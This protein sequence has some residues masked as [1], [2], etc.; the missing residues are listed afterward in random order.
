[1][2]C[3]PSSLQLPLRPPLSRDCRDLLQRLLERDPNRRISFQDFFAHPW[4]DLEHVPSGESLARAVS[5][6]VGWGGVRAG[7]GASS[8]TPFSGERGTCPSLFMVS[9]GSGH[10]SRSVPQTALVVQAV[11]KDQDGDAAAALSLYCKAL[12]FFVPALHC[13]CL[14]PLGAAGVGQPQLRWMDSRSSSPPRILWETK[15][16]VNLELGPFEDS[17]EFGV[18]QGRLL[19]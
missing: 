16:R 9:M 10:D 12:D 14:E 6:L 7:W 15:Q 5:R 4:V 11:K 2:I 8:S 18:G 13:E 17:R 19:M 3:P 1:M